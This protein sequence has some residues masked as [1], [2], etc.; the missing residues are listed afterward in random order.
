MLNRFLPENPLFRLLLINGLIGTA[1][2]ILLVA[3]LMI[4]DA[5]RIGT[6]IINSE[7]PALPIIVLT[8]GLVITFGSVAMGM[9]IMSLPLETDD[10]GTSNSGGHRDRVNALPSHPA[11]RP[12]TVPATRQRQIR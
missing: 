3:G 6:L 4:T 12:I 8:L 7:N 2:A 11:L 5:H 1:V 10:E 9:A